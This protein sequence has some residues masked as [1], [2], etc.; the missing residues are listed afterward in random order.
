[1]HIPQWQQFKRLKI[2]AQ[3]LLF[4]LAA[5]MNDTTIALQ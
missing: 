2:T 4:L 5:S 3:K 1:M